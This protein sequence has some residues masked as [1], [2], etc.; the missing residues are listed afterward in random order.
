MDIFQGWYTD[1]TKGTRD[2]RFLSALCMLF[3]IIALS[4]E[5]VIQMLSDNYDPG[6]PHQEE[7]L[8]VFNIFLGIVFFCVT[9]LQMKMDEFL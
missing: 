5:L 2:Y 8:G 7:I 9:T 4:C 6:L 3:Q 1:G